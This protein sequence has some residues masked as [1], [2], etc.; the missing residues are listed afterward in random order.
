MPLS[1]KDAQI[2][3]LHQ[4]GC[5]V[6]CENALVAKAEQ[7]SPTIMTMTPEIAFAIWI[8][9]CYHSRSSVGNTVL[10]EQFLHD[11]VHGWGQA[12]LV[13]ATLVSFPLDVAAL[14]IFEVVGTR[15]KIARSS[16]ARLPLGVL[17][18]VIIDRSIVGILATYL[19]ISPPSCSIIHR[20][21]SHASTIGCT[22]TFLVFAHI[23]RKILMHT[24]WSRDFLCVFLPPLGDKLLRSTQCLGNLCL[25]QSFLSEMNSSKAILVF[26]VALGRILRKLALA[27]EMRFVKLSNLVLTVELRPLVHP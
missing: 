27:C 15:G 6:D 5:V 12:L 1:A 13:L 26:L 16:I 3:V 14:V 25:G 8:P 18:D 20:L 9:I 24:P 17:Q 4:Q 11:L 21:I 22:N 23:F 19:N 7:G 2:A 10:S